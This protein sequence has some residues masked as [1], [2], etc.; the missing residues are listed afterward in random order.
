MPPRVLKLCSTPRNVMILIRL[1]WLLSSKVCAL[2]RIVALI[3]A[4][5]HKFNRFLRIIRKTY[6]LG[7][8]NFKLCFAPHNVIILVCLVWSMSSHSIRSKITPFW[9]CAK[10][11]LYPLAEKM[12]LQFVALLYS[13]RNFFWLFPETYWEVLVLPEIFKFFQS[14]D[15]HP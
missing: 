12:A 4:D 13:L 5:F 1:V 11:R 15:I 14:F 2:I 8:W 6:L 3:L 7:S 9:S 10:K